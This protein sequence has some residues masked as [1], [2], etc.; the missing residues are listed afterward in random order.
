MTPVCTGRAATLV[1][2]GDRSD[3]SGGCIPPWPKR[4]ITQATY[5]FELDLSRVLEAVLAAMG[6]GFR[7][8]PTVPFR[9]L[10]LH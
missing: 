5:L 2:E 9:E 1:L 8:F 4:M 3:A 7:P 10:I 6:A